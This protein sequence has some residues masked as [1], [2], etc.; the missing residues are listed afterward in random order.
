M[1]YPVV[2]KC[3]HWLIISDFIAMQASKHVQYE[4]TTHLLSPF[5]KYKIYVQLG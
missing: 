4:D 3:S 5:R 2:Y 1:L